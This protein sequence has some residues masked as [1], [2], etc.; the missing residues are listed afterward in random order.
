MDMFSEYDLIQAMSG[1][2][3]NGE[4]RCSIGIRHQRCDAEGQLVDVEEEFVTEKP[5]V[6]VFRQPGGFVLVDLI[7]QSI[8]DQDLKIIYA[9]LDRFFAA[10]NSCSD[11]EDDFPMLSLALFP[12]VLE[13]RYWALGLNPIFYALTPEDSSGE[14]RI[15]RMTFM[16]Q[17]TEDVLPNFLFLASPKDELEKIRNEIDE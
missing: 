8:A 9:Y 13:G 3:E 12:R 15:I 6:Q 7:F 4:G 16:A 2:D 17:E 1:A 11:D 5:V 10:S 14:P